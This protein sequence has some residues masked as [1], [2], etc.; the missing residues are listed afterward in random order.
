MDHFIFPRIDRPPV[1]EVNTADVLEI[2]TL[3]WPV[4]AETVGAVHQH[5][6]PVLE[7]VIARALRN[8]N[9]WD[10]VL[11]VLGPQNDIVTHQLALPH[12][13][14]APAVETMHVSASAAPAIKLAFEFLF[15]CDG[16]CRELRINRS[17]F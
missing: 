8:D 7:W 4:N 15:A 14:V 16:H 13:D 1:S 17:R 11:P 6:R 5:I 3:I 12:K 9:P 2:L 10:R